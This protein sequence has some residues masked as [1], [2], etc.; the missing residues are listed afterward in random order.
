MDGVQR[1]NNRNSG[2]ACNYLLLLVQLV[3]GWWRLFHFEPEQKMLQRQPRTFDFQRNSRVRVVDT[4]V[5]GKLGR[6]SVDKRAE[7]D[8]LHGAANGHF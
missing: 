1:S 4:S 6:Q 3:N 7:T 5:Q 2:S 8:S